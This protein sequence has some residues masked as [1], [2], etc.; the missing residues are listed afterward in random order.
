MGYPRFYGALKEMVRDELLETKTARAIARKAGVRSS[1][2]ST[3]EPTGDIAVDLLQEFAVVTL[4]GTDHSQ[5]GALLNYQTGSN[6]LPPD[7]PRMG[8]YWDFR[9]VTAFRITAN[10]TEPAASGMVIYG[11]L[12]QEGDPG[13]PQVFF[14]PADLEVPID[15]VGF[16]DSGWRDALWPAETGFGRL[17]YLEWYISDPPATEG[18]VGLGLVQ[19]LIKREI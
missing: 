13:S 14:D 2:S 6:W 4:S 7:S 12:Q 16:Y 8:R 19:V 1:G 11:L 5:Y 9:D 15:A 18:T 3:V 10:V 17:G